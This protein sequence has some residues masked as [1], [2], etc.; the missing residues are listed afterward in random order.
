MTHNIDTTATYKSKFYADRNKYTI[1]DI[2]KDEYV[3]LIT[4]YDYVDDED[5]KVNKKRYEICSIEDFNKTYKQHE[6]LKSV[7]VIIFM[8]A[9]DNIKVLTTKQAAGTFLDGEFSAIK[10]VKIDL[11]GNNHETNA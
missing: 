7:D 6:C 4:H 2:K 9:Q 10:C 3:V 1:H 8:D 11:Q 5:K